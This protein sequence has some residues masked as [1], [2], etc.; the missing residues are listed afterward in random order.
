[1]AMGRLAQLSATYEETLQ[2]E[3]VIFNRLP[4]DSIVQEV[5]AFINKNDATFH[6]LEVINE[7]LTARRDR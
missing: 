2:Q 1:M 5:K 6:D 7:D 3:R 4:V